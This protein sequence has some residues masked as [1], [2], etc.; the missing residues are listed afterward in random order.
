[1]KLS[2]YITG[3]IEGGNLHTSQTWDYTGLTGAQVADNNTKNRNSFGYTTRLNFASDVVSNTAYGP[4][5]GHSEMQF[6]NGNGFDNTGNAAYINLAYVT[7]AG[8]TA[9]KAPSFFSFTGGG[10]GWANF[11]SPDQQGFNQPDVLAY[12]ASFGGGFSASLA[13][14]SSGSNGNSGGGTNYSDLTIPGGALIGTSTYTNMLQFGGMQAPDIVANI[15][16]SQGW[17]SAQLS[18]VAHQVN[19]TSGGIAG[20]LVGGVPTPGA[21]APCLAVRMFGAG[22]ST[23]VS[24]STFRR[25]ALAISSCSPGLIL[26]TPYGTRVFPTACGVKTAL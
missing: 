24:A 9:G 16:V 14:Q 13:L 4:L 7:W 22:P 15:K 18:G 10:A 3:Q 26:R 6:E 20:A 8:I 5:A 11:F 2:G 23:R 1:M 17:G 19:V 21:G 25:L 12:T